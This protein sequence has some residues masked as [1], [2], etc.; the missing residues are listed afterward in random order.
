MV[1]RAKLK[2]CLYGS[3]PQMK[4]TVFTSFSLS[5][6]RKLVVVV[7]VVICFFW[8]IRVDLRQVGASWG[9]TLVVSI[10]NSSRDDNNSKCSPDDK[11]SQRQHARV[12]KG[13]RRQEQG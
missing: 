9:A 1:T 10:S 2:V 12:R 3:Q 13:S 8:G 4:T 6:N 7:V 5:N 11:G